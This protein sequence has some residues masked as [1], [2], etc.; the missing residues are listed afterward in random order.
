MSLDPEPPSPFGRNYDQKTAGFIFIGML[1]LLAGGLIFYQIFRPKAAPLPAAVAGDPLLVTGREIYLDRCV[2]C[3]GIEGKGNGPV[4][5]SLA[6]PPTIDL[7]K[8]PW[9]YGDKPEDVLR[10]VDRGTPGSSMAGWGSSLGPQKT[11][12]VS[13][14][15]FYLANKPIPAEFRTAED[16]A[17]KTSAP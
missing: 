10:V 4:A 13:A 5:K 9:K 6:G 11:K 15:V 16:A 12:A 1:T 8:T 3:H 17:K 14:Y 7:T 2:S